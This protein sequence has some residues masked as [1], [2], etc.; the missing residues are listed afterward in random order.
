MGFEWEYQEDHK[1]VSH[2]D[3]TFRHGNAPKLAGMVR[4]LADFSTSGPWTP[5][6]L[7]IH[8]IE[9]LAGGDGEYRSHSYEL[10]K[11]HE[12]FCDEYSILQGSMRSDPRPDL[13][14]EQFFYH[15]DIL[16]GQDIGKVPE[17]LN[18]TRKNLD[19]IDG[20]WAEEAVRDIDAA[21]CGS[22]S[23][24]W[25]ELKARLYWGSSFWTEHWNTPSSE[26]ARDK[27]DKVRLWFDDDT[28]AFRHNALRAMSDSLIQFAATIHG[29]RLSLDNL[30]GETVSQVEA[31][32]NESIPPDGGV[33]LAVLSGIKSVVD[34]GNPIG[35][36]FA[37][38]DAVNSVVNKHTTTKDLASP[39]C[40]DILGSYL[41]G[42]QEIVEEAAAKVEALVESLKH[43]RDERHLFPIPQWGS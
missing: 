13:T 24:K 5:R 20:A 18:M 17:H 36:A 28:G 30:M 26:A 7:D 25:S 43:I 6:Y 3:D 33:T 35:R 11:S 22:S 31:W 2:L 27:Y 39:S 40:Y 1:S 42:A 21:R 41:V 38:T 19:V 29:A 12:M 37:F 8:Q 14:V 34:A 23:V 10:V 32:N 15:A 9:V 16:S 4:S